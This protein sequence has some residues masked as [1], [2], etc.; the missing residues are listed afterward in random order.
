MPPKELVLQ[1]QLG[2]RGVHSS[3]IMTYGVMLSLSSQTE[4]MGGA[5]A[6][7]WV[8]A[9]KEM[10]MDAYAGLT[11]HKQE[12]NLYLRR[13]RLAW[14]ISRWTFVVACRNFEV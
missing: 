5:I 14:N 4:Q 2:H 7:S 9:S 10:T 12:P 1:G 3:L 11:K 13:R 8:K 6:E